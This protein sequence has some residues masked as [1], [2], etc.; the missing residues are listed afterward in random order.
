MLYQIIRNQHELNTFLCV[1]VLEP[2]V[3]GF[4]PSSIV[5]LIHRH[6]I[7]NMILDKNRSINSHPYRS[8][9]T[10]VFSTEALLLFIFSS[11]CIYILTFAVLSL[12]VE[13]YRKYSTIIIICY[14][15]YIVCTN[16]KIINHNLI[17]HYLN[18]IKINHLINVCRLLYLL[19]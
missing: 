12:I 11:Y 13:M 19:L 15:T 18:H 8:S 5:D 6:T 10:S 7:G 17:E 16:T 3:G 1:K 14:T 9:K 2:L 4:R